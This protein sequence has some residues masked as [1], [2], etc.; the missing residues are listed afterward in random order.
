MSGKEEGNLWR[1]M[2]YL[3]RY[4]IKEEIGSGAFATVYDGFDK[5]E[6]RRVAIKRVLRKKREE[7]VDWSALREVKLL[8]EIQHPNVVRVGSCNPNM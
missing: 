1:N 6:K 4:D 5:K 8:Y 7:G 3:T 2:S